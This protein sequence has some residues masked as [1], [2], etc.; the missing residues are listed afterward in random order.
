MTSN[1]IG[2]KLRDTRRADGFFTTHDAL[3]FED[4]PLYVNCEALVLRHHRFSETSL[5][6][7]LY[8]REYGRIDAL[9]KGARRLYSPMRGHFDLF[10]LEEATIFLRRRS[11]LDLATE[12]GLI[13]EHTG[14]RE[15]PRRFAAAGILAEM[16]LGGSLAHD[17]H[18][19][20]FDAAAAAFAALAAGNGYRPLIEG[21]LDV[22][23]EF[24]FLPRLESCPVC[25]C[26]APRAG[27]LS[28]QYGGLLCADC[29]KR[30][31]R[32]E[33]ASVLRPAET[34][35]LRHLLQSRGKPALALP[36]SGLNIIGALGDYCRTVLDKPCRSFTVFASLHR[37][38]P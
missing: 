33:R 29:V 4:V 27:V 8:T 18:P 11:G 24:G 7:T 17:P 35:A 19:A 12:A 26:P 16:L 13:R 32:P 38:Q 23:R 34:A 22:L 10:S 31:T 3:P 30:R 20:A 1:G 2:G 9:A 21:I 15:D 5:I 6:V 14:L 28:G 25:Q 37:R 36:G